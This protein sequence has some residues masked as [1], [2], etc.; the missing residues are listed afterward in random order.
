MGNIKFKG[1]ERRKCFRV[2][3]SLRKPKFQV[4]E[5]EF[6]VADISEMGLRF[7]NVGG[8][9]LGHWVC[10][11]LTLL[12]NV[13][14]YVEGLIVRRKGVDVYINAKPPIQLDLLLREQQYLKDLQ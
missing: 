1:P 11:T 6:E 7:F 12:T 2:I 10:G 13:S 9:D 4:D 5:N 3:Y 8:I 14:I